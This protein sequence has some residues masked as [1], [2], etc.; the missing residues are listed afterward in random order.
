[1]PELPEVEIQCRTLRRWLV[2]RRVLLEDL[3]FGCGNREMRVTGVRRRG[4]YLLIEGKETW[5]LHLRMTGKVVPSRPE[6]RKRARF[7]TL[8]SGQAYDFEDARRLGT[9]AVVGVF[10]DSHLG[11]E[12]WPEKRNASWWRD[13]LQGLRSP[14]KPALM[15]Q[16]R[17]AGLGNIAASEILFR[18]GVDPRIRVPD[19][20]RWKHIADAA[21]AFLG[22]LIAEEAGEE[23]LYVTQGGSN[24]FRV[25]QRA[26]CPTCA[27]A[28]TRLVQ[29]GRATFFCPT[30]Q[31][32]SPVSGR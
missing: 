26:Q 19:V 25:Y 32:I 21:H 24:P 12:P 28:I 20:R 16:D 3:D 29:S 11:P 9:L 14:I 5:V 23:I 4:K 31:P 17:V 7:H 2:G 22:E 10:D 30:C 1:M 8:Q 15:R 18:A 6:G 27:T 13:R